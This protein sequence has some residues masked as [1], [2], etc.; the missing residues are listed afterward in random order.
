MMLSTMMF[1]TAM[2][3]MFST[4]MFWM[5]EFINQPVMSGPPHSPQ[6]GEVKHGRQILGGQVPG[7]VNGRLNLHL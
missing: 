1:S 3:L 5:M 7:G 6:G 2:F 4:A